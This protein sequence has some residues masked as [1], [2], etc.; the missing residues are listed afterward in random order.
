MVLMAAVLSPVNSPRAAEVPGLE[1]AAAALR[2]DAIRSL[3]F[4][5]DGKYYQFGQAPAPELAWPA[6][7]VDSYVATL[8]FERA[9]IHARYHRVQVQEPGRLRPHSEQTM[10]QFALDG[11]TWNLTP[12]PTAIPTN[13][14]ERNAEIWASPQ[15]F[16]KA[17]RANA[18]ALRDVPDGTAVTFTLSG[19]FRYEGLL[20]TAGEVVHVRTFMDSNVLGDTPIEWRYSNYRDFGGVRFPARIER[21]VAELPWYELAV[22]AVRINTAVVFEI[23]AAIAANPAPLASAVEVTELAPGVWLLG[24]GTHNSVVIEQ[25]SGV[26]IVETPLNEQRADAVLAKARALVPAKPIVAV[27]NTHAHFDH[28]GGLRTVAAAG[29]PI[30]THER[31]A[32]FYERAW[33]QPR[34]LVPDRLAEVKRKPVFRNFTRRLE[35]PDDRHPIEIHA[36][37]GS[38]HND[39]FAMV[40]LPADKLLV[41]ADAWTPTPPGAAPPAAVNPLWVNLHQN[42]RRLGLD[43]QR[44]APLHG[45]PQS[46]ETFRAAIAPARAAN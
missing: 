15:G 23:P 38:G 14:A 13:L 20:N 19:G 1:H 12:A 43:V 16:I 10:D 35:L 29:I 33:A 31:N 6:F 28:A 11:V 41:E 22:S 46:L 44:F 4:V 24:G 32:R 30:V 17:A 42:I 40:Y 8:D 18:A 3:E 39:A 27:I 45:A 26:V 21:R 9:A 37:A 25:A 7:A 34:S 36:I 2:V 5:A